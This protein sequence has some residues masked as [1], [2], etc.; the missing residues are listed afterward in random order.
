MPTAVVDGLVTRYEV[1]GSGPPLLMFSPGGFDASLEGWRS[2]GVYRRLRL[3]DHLTRH[4]TCI[5]FDRRESGGSGGRLER[6]SWADYV[7]QG[8]GLLDALGV[9]RA[10]LMGGCVGCS[11]VAAVAVAH[12]ER[13]LSMVLYSPAGG[14]RYRMKQH[15]RFVRHLAYADTE[16][17]DRVVALARSTDAGFTADPRVGPWVNVI[18]RDAGFAARYADCDPERYRTAVSGM[19][20]LLFDRDTVPGPEPEDLL[21]LDVP[22]L[23]VPGQDDSHATSAARYL[24]ECLQ[25]ARYW[26]VPVAE[27]TE[28]TAPARILDFLGG[29]SAAAG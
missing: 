23:I 18:R 20:R 1:A 6:I 5:T 2:V 28:L 7:R 9:E 13:V 17:L 15:A 29:V 3:L 25:G 11:T 16:G 24:Q 21:G 26:D 8:V 27:Q 4:Y 14:A 12:P 10:H 22:A 19:V